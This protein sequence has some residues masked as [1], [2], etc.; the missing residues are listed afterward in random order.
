MLAVPT[1]P[2]LLDR[3]FLCLRLLH[4]VIAGLLVVLR[5]LHFSSLLTLPLQPLRRGERL[6]L[7]AASAATA[8]ERESVLRPGCQM[9]ADSEA[10]C[11]FTEAAA[12]AAAVVV[13]AER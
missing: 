11:G 3:L 2:V 7:R 1:G 9:T 8:A 12:A 4:S 13:P 5:H 6:H 10:P